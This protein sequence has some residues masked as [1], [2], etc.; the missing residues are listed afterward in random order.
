MSYT[1]RHQVFIS[2]TFNDLKDERAEV[3]QAIWELDGIPTG[4]EAF[5]ASNDSQ[6]D[7]ITRVIDQCDYYVLII[8]GRYGSTTLDGLSYTEKEYNYAKKIGLPVL[9]FVHGDPERIP[10]GKVDKDPVKSSALASFRE[11][12]MRAHPV[13]SWTTGSE[14]GGLVSRSLIKE[15]RLNPRPGWIRNDGSSPVALLEQISKLTEENQRLRVNLEAVTTSV[16]EVDDTL[17]RGGDQIVLSG[18]RTLTG[19]GIVYR[20][21]F[22]WK[23]AATWDDLFR[24]IGPALI[25]ETSEDEMKGIISRF[26]G[27]A[28]DPPEGQYE[29]GTAYITRECWNEVIVQL[30][31]LGYV[32]PGTKKRGV[33]DKASYWVI[34]QRGDAHLLTLLARRKAPLKSTEAKL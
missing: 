31:A 2:S 17:E 21:E 16:D 8:G 18:F 26:S 4:M 27:W 11:A 23:A 3:I 30:R 10:V 25:N 20:E 14:L 7:I 15:T 24:D 9:A 1:I 12:V 34:T 22:A 6:W 32:S 28:E 19:T 5:L 29:V 13:R 33:N